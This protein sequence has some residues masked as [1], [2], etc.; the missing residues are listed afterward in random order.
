MGGQVVRMYTI[1]VRRRQDPE[2]VPTFLLAPGRLDEDSMQ[3]MD[4]VLALA[5]EVGVRLI[6]PLLNNWPWMGGV[7][8]YADF[9]GREESE[10]WTDRQLIE[11]FKRTVELVLT[12]TN[13]LTGVDYRDDRAILCWETGN[14][15]A[16]PWAWTH[17]IAG[18]CPAPERRA[19]PR[20][21]RE[22]DRDVPGH[23]ARRWRGPEDRDP[24]SAR[25]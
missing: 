24:A 20:L 5:N 25:R 16:A 21:G 19:D 14:E 22:S 9:R 2:D 17:E 10:F 8:Q 3:A 1:P 12:R 18:P 11:D 7:P 6:V 13:T 15:L 23:R 4:R